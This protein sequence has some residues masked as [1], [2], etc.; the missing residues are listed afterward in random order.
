MPI[1]RHPAENITMRE[2]YDRYDENVVHLL[3]GEYDYIEAYPDKNIVNDNGE[4]VRYFYACEDACIVTVIRSLWTV[5]LARQTDISQ[6]STTNAHR[7]LWSVV[8]TRTMWMFLTYLQQRLL[9]IVT[10]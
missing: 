8:L 5:F 6:L 4:I 9:T 3:N 1:V 7:R 2:V 10:G